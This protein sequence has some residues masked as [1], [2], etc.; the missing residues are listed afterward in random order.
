MSGESQFSNLG[1]SAEIDII[2]WMYGVSP[3]RIYQKIHI[4]PPKPKFS[5]SPQSIFLKHLFDGSAMQKMGCFIK[6]FEFFSVLGGMDAKVYSHEE[7]VYV[8]RQQARRWT[9]GRRLHGWR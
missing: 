2:Q 9:T 8:P 3:T 6:I 7:T 4:G 1:Q 5:R